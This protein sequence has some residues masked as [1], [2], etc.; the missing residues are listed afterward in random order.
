MI[1]HRYP[2]GGG[3]CS[4]SF[5]LGV[6]GW[7]RGGGRTG[8]RHR[9]GVTRGIAVG[10]G[11]GLGLGHGGGAG[12]AGSR[13][14]GGRTD[15]GQ[16]VR[17]GNT[18]DLAG[19]DRA[20]GGAHA[21]A[22][23]PP[24]H[25]PEFGGEAVIDHRVGTVGLQLA[26]EV[27]A[28]A[29]AIVAALEVNLGAGV[30]V[31]QV[32]ANDA[33]VGVEL[34]PGQR[35]AVAEGVAPPLHRRRHHDGLD[36]VLV[37]GRGQQDEDLVGTGVDAIDELYVQHWIAAVEVTLGQVVLDGRPFGPGLEDEAVAA[38]QR[39]MVGEVVHPRLLGHGLFV[40]DAVAAAAVKEHEDLLGG[41]GCRSEQEQQGE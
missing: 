2:T 30:V 34:E 40:T 6:D 21:V 10:S 37:A 3:G 12:L 33:I 4:G 36:E 20:P 16:V 14:G 23:Q 18:V 32:D 39:K 1:D 41:Q 13:G 15:G 27:V 9:L 11:A 19:H 35:R 31:G 29:G 28:G 17:Y 8:V 38:H 24:L 22:A 5:R 26:E 7:V 25:H